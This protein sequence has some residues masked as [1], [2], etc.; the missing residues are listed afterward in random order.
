MIPTL[1]C[2]SR[3]G[4]RVYTLRPKTLVWAPVEWKQE[5]ANGP[6]YYL[7]RSPRSQPLTESILIAASLYYSQPIEGTINGELRCMLENSSPV[8]CEE[9]INGRAYARTTY[10]MGK[11][12]VTLRDSDEDGY[13]ET[14]IH[15]H[16][17]E[18]IA[19]IEIDRNANR[20]IE[21]ME[22]YSVDGTITKKWDS[23]EDGLFE[24]E[25]EITLEGK[26]KSRW[27]HPVTGITVVT[28]MENG[29]PR[30]VMYGTLTKPII[31]DP[32]AGIFWI[33]RIPPNSR[34]IAEKILIKLNRE[35]VTVVCPMMEIELMH[36]SAVRTG[37]FV[38]VEQINAK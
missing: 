29:R 7:S 38:F 35:P 18:K 34:T 30:S 26:E 19:S 21:Y 24:I 31:E 8:I 25:W 14:K 9:R 27:I 33:G 16:S 20:K 13:F 10:Q 4:N 37:G 2:A 5:T 23:D 3:R 12:D 22:L 1:S 32:S 28:V 36:F 6:F 15:Y 11:P 17:D